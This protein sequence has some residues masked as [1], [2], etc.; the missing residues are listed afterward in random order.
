MVI[1]SVFSCCQSSLQSLENQIDTKR[2]QLH[3]LERLYSTMEFPSA[4][5]EEGKRIPDKSCNE[6]I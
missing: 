3:H 2:K 5:L 4:Q 1:N 6:G